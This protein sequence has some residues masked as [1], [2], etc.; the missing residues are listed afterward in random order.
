MASRELVPFSIDLDDVTEYSKELAANIVQN[1]RRYTQLASD[2]IFEMLPEYQDP[3]HPVSS[4]RPLEY[5][6]EVLNFLLRIKS[7]KRLV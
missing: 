3:Q 5:C 1:A 6:V 7:Y 2:A 4:L